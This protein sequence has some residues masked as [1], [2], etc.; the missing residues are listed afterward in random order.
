MGHDFEG[1]KGPYTNGDGAG[2]FSLRLRPWIFSGE[3]RPT[4]R[5]VL[6]I[7]AAVLFSGLKAYSQT[8]I[9]E[10]C[11][12]SS[13]TA[14]QEILKDWKSTTAKLLCEYENQVQEQFW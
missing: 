14:V 11:A 6:C 13:L 8:P 1:E 5:S 7:C 3:I 4:T 12:K 9:S 10:T 2:P